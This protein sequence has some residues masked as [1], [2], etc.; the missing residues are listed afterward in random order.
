MKSTFEIESKIINPTIAK[1]TRQTALEYLFLHPEFKYHLFLHPKFK[2]Q[3][4]IR[5]NSKI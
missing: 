5:S 1:K 3:T 2:H 4:G